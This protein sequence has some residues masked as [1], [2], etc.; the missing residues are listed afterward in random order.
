MLVAIF[1]E[2]IQPMN[3]ER[4]KTKSS[5][6][7]GQRRCQ[8]R[9]PI[10]SPATIP[11]LFMSLLPFPLKTE[12]SSV[13]VYHDPKTALFFYV[14]MHGD[15][16][17]MIFACLGCLFLNSNM[18]EW[19]LSTS[20][21]RCF[22]TNTSQNQASDGSMESQAQELFSDVNFVARDP[23]KASQSSPLR[24]SLRIEASTAL[25]PRSTSLVRRGISLPLRSRL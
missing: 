20:T 10:P 24:N 19:D 16:L 22:S 23:R 15:D 7:L 4:I 1:I 17:V 5:S 6:P 2:A 11:R 25:S 8:A 21:T 9:Q 14:A 13:F 3:D 12:Q 18:V